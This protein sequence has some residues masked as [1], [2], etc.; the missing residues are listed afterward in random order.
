MARRSRR[1]RARRRSVRRRALWITLALGLGIA[2]AALALRPRS[3]PAPPL[4]PPR[5]VPP[6][7]AHAPPGGAGA[8][9]PE[10]PGAGAAAE[11]DG[12]QPARVAIV[13]DDLGDSLES[14]RAVLALEPPVTVAVL[15]FRPASTAVAAAAVERGC[16][17]ILHLPLEPEQS[18]AIAGARG[19]LETAMSPV[20]LERQ[21]TA[22][23]AAVPYIVGV[24][25]HMGSRFTADGAAMEEL[26]GALHARGL[27]F[28]DSRSSSASVAAATASR[29]GVP[30]AART[31]FLDHD[32]APA[33]IAGELTRLVEVARRAGEAI[34]IGHPHRE[35]IAALGPWLAAAR[36][37][38][39]AIVPASA[40]A[41]Q[42]G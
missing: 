28:L 38:G 17:V 14:A 5:F 42:P 39:I 29:V 7:A 30:F 33:A 9:R 18:V 15:P 37:R 26:L 20:R 21:L 36:Q 2:A 27:F 11:P 23:L 25:G 12:D 8:T 13:I 3:L 24:N 19:F 16:E 4:S 22:D 10:R 34:A 41:R 31:L 1:R 6:Q 40:L 32:P 35:T